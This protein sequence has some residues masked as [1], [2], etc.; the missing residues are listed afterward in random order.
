[1]VVSSSSEKPRHMMMKRERK[2]RMVRV[3]E[4]SK[5]HRQVGHHLVEKGSY[6]KLFDQ[7]KPLS[8]GDA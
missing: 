7:T 6:E 2:V 4:A 1:M 8:Q 3:G 5:A